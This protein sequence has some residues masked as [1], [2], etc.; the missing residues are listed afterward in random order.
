M[1]CKNL[2][3]IVQQKINV[4]LKM[5][6]ELTAS[7]T[8]IEKVNILIEEANLLL[9]NG[10]YILKLKINFINFEKLIHQSYTYKQLIYE[11]IYENTYSILLT[12][13]DKMFTFTVNL[14][15]KN[16]YILEKQ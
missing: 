10:H 11:L 5:I 2:I 15:N 8:A 7:V 1:P 3:L 4:I 14:S 16:I 6:D 13:S 12:S 9:Q